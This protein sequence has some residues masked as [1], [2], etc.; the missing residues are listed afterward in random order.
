MPVKI[1]GA[2]AGVSVGP[3]GGTHQAIEDIALMR[4]IPN[5]VV[6]VPCDSLEAKK[7]TLALAATTSPGY[8]RLAREKSPIVTREDT[9]FEIGK[10]MV[11]YESENSSSKK[12]GIIACGQMVAESL[13]AAKILEKEGIEVG[14]MN[15]ATIKPLDGKAILSFAQKYG[16]IVTAEEH[17]KA[18]G[19]GSTV[20]EFLSE[21]HPTKIAFVGISDAFGQS[22][23]PEELL[24]FYG[25]DKSAIVGKAKKLLENE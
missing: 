21:N 15:L 16:K 18:G 9:P 14:V 12:V 23:T 4:V 7:A 11:L 8:I 24:V 10:A 25:L 19:M 13:F 17:Q 3:D 1:A 6:I 20:A 2:H 5:S 22:G